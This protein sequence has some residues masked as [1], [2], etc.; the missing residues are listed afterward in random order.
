M[1]RCL[2]SPDSVERQG[3]RLYAIACR[4]D[5]SKLHTLTC[6]RKGLKSIARNHTIY[7]VVARTFRQCRIPA[8]VSS[9]GHNPVSSSSGREELGP[10][11]IDNVTE[12]RCL[13]ENGG[14]LKTKS[15]VIDFTTTN[16][17]G[18]ILL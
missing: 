15:I 9:R 10:I 14:N 4:E 11:R 12:R 16:P 7:H 6:L 1:G 5:A 3:G 2:G 8:S 13:F 18:N 17:C